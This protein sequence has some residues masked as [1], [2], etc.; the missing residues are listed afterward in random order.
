MRARSAG[1]FPDR[2]QRRRAG[3]CSGGRAILGV[4][5]PDLHHSDPALNL[6]SDEIDVEQTIIQPRTAHLDPFRQYEGP[7]ELAGRNAAMQ[8]DALRIICL[9]AAEDQL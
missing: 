7:L 8:V 6:G 5:F 9:L 2:F 4:A 1:S 3:G